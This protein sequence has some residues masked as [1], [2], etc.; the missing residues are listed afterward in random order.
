MVADIRALASSSLDISRTH[1]L[2]AVA[3]AYVCKTRREVSATFAWSLRD[4]TAAKDVALAASTGDVIECVGTLLTAGNKY[5][6]TVVAT[7]QMASVAAH[8]KG[9]NS[10][11]FI[12]TRPRAVAV[13]LGGERRSVNGADAVVLALDSSKLQGKVGRDGNFQS[14]PAVAWACAAVAG[15]CPPALADALNT[16]GARITI[17]AGVPVGTYVITATVGSGIDAS[18]AKQTLVID[19]VVAKDQIAIFGAPTE[20]QL[21]SGA[22]V[23]LYARVASADT[24]VSW[25]VNGI[26]QPASALQFKLNPTLPGGPTFEVKATTATGSA[27]ITITFPRPVVGS[28]RVAPADGVSDIVSLRTAITISST[29]AN[30]DPSRLR[31]RYYVSSS[32]D[33]T[34]LATASS[35]LA[36]LTVTAPYVAGI[37]PAPARFFVVARPANEDRTI[38][39]AE[40]SVT[41]AP[42][43]KMD[44]TDLRTNA[45]AKI[46]TSA[47]N[48][49]SAQAAQLAGCLASV[50]AGETDAAKKSTAQSDAV[51]AASA[52]TSLISGDASRTQRSALVKA[53][54]AVLDSQNPVASATAAPRA[55]EQLA[56]LSATVQNQIVS[57]LAKATA[58]SSDGSNSQNALDADNDGGCALAVLNSVTVRGKPVH[59]AAVNLAFAFA[60]QAPLGSNVIVG[61]EG[62]I[63]VAG[64]TFPGTASSVQLRGTDSSVTI[65]ANHPF[66]DLANTYAVSAAEFRENHLNPTDAGKPV[67]TTRAS[68]ICDVSVQSNGVRRG[69]QG[70]ATPVSLSIKLDPTIATTAAPR[71]TTSAPKKYTCAFLDEA[72]NRWSTQGVVT[73]RFDPAT[74]TVHCDTTHLTAFTIFADDDAAASSLNNNAA[75]SSPPSVSAQAASMRTYI[76]AGACA[77]SALLAL[78]ALY[79][80]WR[81]GR[82]GSGSKQ[83]DDSVNHLLFTAPQDGYD[84]ELMIGRGRGRG[85]ASPDI[86]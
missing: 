58:L 21:L 50:A 35:E 25:A 54:R 41:I 17:A 43:S 53:V 45:A 48:K 68:P 34:A 69:V 2:S 81:R 83:G 61:S 62:K 57:T 36:S 19:G 5:T 59:D 29:W 76:I 49:D 37:A 55:S 11:S 27:S 30:I 52:L 85:S 22:P 77:G 72:T 15:T 26:A 28:C 31:Y 84:E 79:V 12:A 70:L 74:N 6:V 40:C 63:S 38:A 4:D 73:N 32:T 67:N 1:R 20:G 42:P 56:H 24:R 14:L 64:T 3:A 33:R 47:N 18:T 16:A 75:V 65:P 78:I 44:A 8:P 9:S 23:L 60:S 66:S 80:K 10:I 51:N 13:I 7:L 71:T 86:I 82:G 46:A 39:T